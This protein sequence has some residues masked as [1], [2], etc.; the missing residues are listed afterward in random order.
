M[1]ESIDTEFPC[2]ACTYGY[3]AAIYGRM[4]AAGVS[5]R[6]RGA[7]MRW[8]VG[9]TMA[10]LGM[11]NTECMLGHRLLDPECPEGERGARAGGGECACT[12]ATGTEHQLTFSSLHPMVRLR[13]EYLPRDDESGGARGLFV[14]LSVGTC[15]VV[16]QESFVP[17]ALCKAPGLLARRGWHG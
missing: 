15:V 8:D 4:S 14:P 1:P 6:R 12:F 17:I 13:H 10:L 7:E 5:V 2:G 3:L 9:F 11:F 16:W